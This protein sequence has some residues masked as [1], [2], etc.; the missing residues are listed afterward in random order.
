MCNTIALSTASLLLLILLSSFGSDTYAIVCTY[1]GERHN[2]G[3]RWVV[4]SAFIIECHVYPDGSWR[5]DVVAC[6]TPKGIEM[7]DGDEIMEDDVKL[8]CEKLPSGGYR[9]Q[10][11]YF[12]QNITCEGHKFGEWWISKRNF[13]KTCSPTGTYI[14]NC[15]TDTGIPI[16]LNRSVILSGTRYNCTGHSNGLVT[17]TRDFPRNFHITS[18]IEQIYCTVNDV[19]K[20]INETWIE[21]TNFIKK[22]NERAVTIVKACIADG[23]IIDLNSKLTRNGKTYACTGSDNGN[24]LFKI[25]PVIDN[26]THSGSV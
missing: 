14:M 3:D 22:C 20:K 13:N 25:M 23:F 12:N 4:R 21:D 19:Q 11:F 18:K 24:V 15:L 26:S 17:F 7:H 1:M 8:Q 2:D 9:M 10:K 5:A 6:Q 16:E